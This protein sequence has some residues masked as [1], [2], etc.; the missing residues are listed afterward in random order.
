MRSITN[1]ITDALIESGAVAENQR[2]LYHYCVTGVLEIG[3]NLIITL[4]IGLLMGKLIETLLFL[5]IMIPLRRTAGGYHSDSSRACF[6]ISILLYITTILSA[7]FLADSLHH[8]HSAWIFAVATTIILILSPVDSKN[9]RLDDSEKKRFRKQSFLLV[10]LFSI[11]FAVL[12]LLGSVSF[13]YLISCSM[14]MIA[15]MLLAG[16]LKNNP[17]FDRSGV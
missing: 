8:I 16:K 14:T 9:K 13:C 6:I 2:K 4:T 17:R 1:E 12:F 7:G 3:I 11:G 10:L 15:L 5:L